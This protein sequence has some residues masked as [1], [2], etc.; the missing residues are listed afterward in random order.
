MSSI[1]LKTI[2][3]LRT[4][5]ESNEGYKSLYNV[6]FIAAILSAIS[7]IAFVIGGMGLPDVSTISDPLEYFL[8]Y[9]EAWTAYVMYSWGGVLGTLLS[10]PYILAFYYAMKDYGPMILLAMVTAL[11]G[12]V[13]T[14]FG[15]FETLTI[16]YIHLPHA[17]EAS[18]D[19]LQVIRIASEV[20]EGMFEAP[21]FLG[22][23][24]I[25][26]LGFGLLA[27]YGLRSAIG[28]K[29]VN[30]VGLLGGLSGVVWLNLFLAFIRPFS[31]VLIILNI[32]TIFIWSLGLTFA[33]M[34]AGPNA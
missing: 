13:F 34:R 19:Q 20:A 1:D 7:W 15:F 2:T 23:F 11:V 26:S 12:A 8:A 6:A 16:M 28:P 32:L 29:W 21:W 31:T 14:V 30:V 33:L 25:F 17:L 4:N 18:A 5:Q 3:H 10:I 22:S 9:Q 27:Y 24:L